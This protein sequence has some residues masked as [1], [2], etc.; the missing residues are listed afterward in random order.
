MAKPFGK[1]PICGIKDWQPRLLGQGTIYAC[2]N[3]G[4]T[5]TYG[6]ARL[7]RPG[8]IDVIVGASLWLYIGSLLILIGLALWCG[9]GGGCKS[10]DASLQPSK[11]FDSRFNGVWFGVD[12]LA[13][14]DIPNPGAAKSIFEEEFYDCHASIVDARVRLKNSVNKEEEIGNRIRLDVL[15]LRTGLLAKFLDLPRPTMSDLNYVSAERL[16]VDNGIYILMAGTYW[17]GGE[18]STSG[19]VV[20]LHPSLVYSADEEFRVRENEV[21]TFEMVGNN[22]RH[23][24]SDLRFFIDGVAH[25]ILNE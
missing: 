6:Q 22:L 24:Q 2:G 20:R 8:L 25:E 19:N 16:W 3:C 9:V 21:V 5:L 14:F 1:C 18:C 10:S 12:H 4:Y 15:T 13:G 17:G 7:T 11:N 23:G